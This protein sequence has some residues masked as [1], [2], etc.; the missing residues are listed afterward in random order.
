MRCRFRCRRD[1]MIWRHGHLA[2][3]GRCVL[4]QHRVDRHAAP[5]NVKPAA[6]GWPSPR[7]VN[8]VQ[9]LA[10]WIEERHAPAATPTVAAAWRD[11]EDGSTLDRAKRLL[12]AGYRPELRASWSALVGGLAVSALAFVVLC[13]GTHAGVALAAEI[14]LP[15]QRIEKLAGERDLLRPLSGTHDACARIFVSVCQPRPHFRK[16]I[17]QPTLCSGNLTVSFG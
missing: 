16:L 8:Y 2:E 17:L 7:P 3:K 1:D 12:V 13:C 4:G 6:I 5:Q 9:A 11:P 15:T 10:N 14:L